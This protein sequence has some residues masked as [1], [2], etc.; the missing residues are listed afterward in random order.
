MLGSG[1]PSPATLHTRSQPLPLCPARHRL[2][3]RCRH[4]LLGR[5]TRHHLCLHSRRRSPLPPR[6][7]SDQEATDAGG[8]VCAQDPPPPSTLGIRHRPQSSIV[9]A[10]LCAQPPSTA[11]DRRHH[12]T[13]VRR[14]ELAPAMDPLVSTWAAR[15]RDVEA[16]GELELGAL[17][18][19]LELERTRVAAPP[20]LKIRIGA[21]AGVGNGG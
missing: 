7:G 18:V 5:S 10:I 20:S 9:A 2:R 4:L 3:H 1:Q 11:L 8:V 6:R 19:A 15:I 21:R 17:L 13:V 12:H 14:K 16:H